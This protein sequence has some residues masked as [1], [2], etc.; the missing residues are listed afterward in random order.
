MMC[1]FGVVAATNDE[2]TKKR[3]SLFI[4]WKRYMR[5]GRWKKNGAGFT[6]VEL[7]VVISIIAILLAVLVP[8]LSKAREQGRT[9]V[10]RSNQ[11]QIVLG[12]S[13]WAKDH[14]DWT[15]ACHWS[16]PKYL[17]KEFGFADG[18][19]NPTSLEPYIAASTDSKG[20]VY[21]CPSAKGVEFF[22]WSGGSE[23][24]DE[25]SMRLTYAINGWLATFCDFNSDGVG[26]SPGTK[27][28]PKF[29]NS[30][31]AGN[32]Y[33]FEHGVTKLINIRHPSQTLF[34]TDLAYTVAGPGF[35]DPLGTRLAWPVA[36]AW[37]GK[38]A[39]NS[40]N[41]ANTGIGFSNIGWVD[42]SVSKQPKD[43]IDKPKMGE[44]PRWCYYLWN[45]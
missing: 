18:A 42:G 15:P 45:H 24:F 36:H 9:V 28:D 39:A 44:F 6:L 31:A 16:E 23:I 40:S 3:Y 22:K 2:F 17:K 34:F 33:L 35:F 8:A 14:E 38:K 11:K 10:C 32:P 25:R 43:F 13:L 26:E 29:K 37:H 12:A 1:S 19:Y 4:L 41:V 21:V 27:P 30:S 20:M 7:L 5:D